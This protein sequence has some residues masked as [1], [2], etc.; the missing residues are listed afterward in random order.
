MVA[1]KVFFVVAVF[2]HE[3]FFLALLSYQAKYI[4]FQY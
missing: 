4:F 1:A 3:M 2:Y